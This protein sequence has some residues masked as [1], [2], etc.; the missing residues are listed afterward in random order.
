MGA[1]QVL[2]EMCNQDPNGE[3][4]RAFMSPDNFIEAKQGK[5]G[6]GW[7]KMAVDNTTMFRM[8][9]G[10][11][12]KLVLFAYDIDKYKEVE[13]SLKESEPK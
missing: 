1:F 8:L 10:Q 9:T 2:N 12:I 6:W 11:K 4:L 3:Y 13:K 5:G 7:I